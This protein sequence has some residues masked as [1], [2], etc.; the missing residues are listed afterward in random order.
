MYFIPQRMS[1]IKIT[2][3]D[4]EN[5]LEMSEYGIGENKGKFA[6]GGGYEALLQGK[7]WREWHMRT[8][9]VG[10][11]EGSMFKGKDAEVIE[12]VYEQQEFQT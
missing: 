12:S 6:Q 4:V 10:V 8:W 3:K 5:F 11:V 7:R 1:H 9:E 2:D